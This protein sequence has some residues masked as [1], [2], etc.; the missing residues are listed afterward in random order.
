[1]LA[2]LGYHAILD[3]GTEGLPE[4]LVL[5]PV[6]LLELHQLPL[7]L[8]L[9]GRGNDLQLAGVLEHLPADVQGEIL[10]VHHA[11][12]KAEVVR[13]Q[14]GT[15]VHDEHAGAVK[16]KP[17]LI[18]PGIEVVGGVGGDIEHGL[19]GDGALGAGVDHGQGVLP[20]PKFLLVEGVVLLRLHF[21][22]LPL[23]Q[24]HHG[25]EGLPLLHCLPLGLVVLSGVGGL[26]LL[27]VVLHLHHDGIADIVGV[28]F[29]Q[30]L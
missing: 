15:L 20:V 25:V 11:P 16:L 1:M 27:T 18:L 13:E 17:F 12:D 23:P 5:L 14:V 24:G 21:A 30:L 19:V 22:L 10:G 8:L 4:C 26:L 28:F 7:D 3:L 6:L 9:Q 2:V 29:D